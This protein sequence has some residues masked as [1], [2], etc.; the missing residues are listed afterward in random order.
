MW[1][2][3]GPALSSRC[4]LVMLARRCCELWSLDRWDSR[5][6]ERATQASVGER[7]ARAMRGRLAVTPAQYRR[8]AYVTLVALTLI[9]LTG[10][11]V[12]LTGSGLGCPDWP[13]CYGKALPPLSTHALIEFG[14]RGLSGL[15]GVLTVL[16]AA[17]AFIRRPF[18]RDLAWLACLLPLGV[19]AQAVLGGFTVREHLA[20]GFVMAHF[21][22]SMIL[23]IAAAALA[24]RAASEPGSRSRSADRLVVWSVRAL[25]PFGALTIFAGTAATA[26]GPHAGGSPGQR[27]HR[28]HFKGADTLTWVIHRHATIAALFGVAVVA[29]WLLHRRRTVTAESSGALAVAIRAPN[30]LEPLTVL[31]VLL[32]AQGLVGSVQYELTLPADMVWVHVTLATLTW[33]AILWAVAAAG[34]LPS[35]AQRPRPAT[36]AQAPPPE[37]GAEA[38]LVA[39]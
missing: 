30:A 24:W 18:R 7:Y 19:V 17:L 29:V 32:A 10:A 13:K 35:R 28:L 9:V 39:R 2:S 20:P 25:A 8:V 15:V 38:T 4:R 14:N 36:A 22:L 33:L 34:R 21:G 26:A 11:A 23:L 3:S 6:G 27:I 1:G 12:R 5:R 31:A 16:A 37:R